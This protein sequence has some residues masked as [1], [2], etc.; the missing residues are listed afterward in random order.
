MNECDDWVEFN[1]PGEAEAIW[2][3]SMK[4]VRFIADVNVSKEI[5]E[6]ISSA[7]IDVIYDERLRY[8]N[9]DKASFIDCSGSSPECGGEMLLQGH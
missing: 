1:I 8:L 3:R 9:D 2:G 5:V 4:K 6:E 7:G